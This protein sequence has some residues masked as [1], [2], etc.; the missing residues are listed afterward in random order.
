MI[1]ERWNER[2]F[3]KPLTRVRESVQVLREILAGGRGPGGFKLETPA[4]SH[5]HRRL[6]DRM[7]RLGGELGDG[8]FVNFLPLS[9]V[10]HVVARVREGEAGRD[11]TEIICR[12]FCVPAKRLGVARFMFAAYRHGTGH[13]AFFGRSAGATRSTRW[14][15]PGARATARARLRG[16]DELV[17]EI[18]ILGDPAA[19][20]ERLGAFAER[21]ITT[22]VLTDRR[23][24]LIEALARDR[25]PGR[26]PLLVGS[27]RPR[28]HRVPRRRVGPA[29]RRPRAVR[30]AVAGGIPDPGSADDLRNDAA[31]R[32]AL[33]FEIG[34]GG[35]R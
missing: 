11:P 34:G 31:F 16:A 2:P 32:A 21:G 7:L 15:P 19:M 14:W 6:R 8:T 28:V 3:A 33:Q 35:L 13:E 22:L 23:P 26:G 24:D 1:V 4:P 20:K 30:E 27:S 9:S 12:F 18:F 10:E 17:R 5:R 29:R 25:R